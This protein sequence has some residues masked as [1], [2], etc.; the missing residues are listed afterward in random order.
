M[1]SRFEQ[2]VQ[3]LKAQENGQED[4]NSLMTT[5]IYFV[6]N[7]TKT[8]GNARFGGSESKKE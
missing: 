6:S 7:S 4:N 1:T 2:R 8:F 5:D 3:N